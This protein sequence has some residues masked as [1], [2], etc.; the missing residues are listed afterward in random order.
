M[1]KLF[2]ENVRRIRM[3]AGISQELLAERCT[4]YKRQIP[5]IE[6][7]T[8]KVNLS[9]IVVLAEALEVD[10]GTL[11]RQYRAHS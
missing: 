10:P 8:A 6:N 4:K 11:L 5:H 3:E 9:M 2:S 1:L 7:G